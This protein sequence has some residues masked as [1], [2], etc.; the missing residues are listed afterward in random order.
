MLLLEHSPPC[1]VEA[2]I[3]VFKQSMNLAVDDCSI[4]V[5]RLQQ[6]HIKEQIK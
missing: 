5:H 4:I 1:L 6:N 3:I 2:L